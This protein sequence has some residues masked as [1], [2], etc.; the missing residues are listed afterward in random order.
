MSHVNVINEVKKYGKELKAPRLCESESIQ[1]MEGD[2][3]HNYIGQKNY[4]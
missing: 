2:E 3:L 1:A 4:A